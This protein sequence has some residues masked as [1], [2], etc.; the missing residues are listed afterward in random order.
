[1]RANQFLRNV[2]KLIRD[3]DNKKNFETILETNLT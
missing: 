1:M 2:L 3:R